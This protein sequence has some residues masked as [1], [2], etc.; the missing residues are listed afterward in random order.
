MARPCCRRAAPRPRSISERRRSSRSP[1]GAARWRRRSAVPST[2][3]SQ[4]AG[5]RTCRWS[6][7]RS[8]QLVPRHR[9]RHRR[10]A[11]S[12]PPTGAADASPRRVRVP[13]TELCRAPD[14]QRAHPR[15]REGGAPRRGRC[16]SVPVGAAGCD[17]AR[18][19]HAVGQCGDPATHHG[20]VPDARGLLHDRRPAGR[21]PS[22]G[23]VRRRAVGATSTPSN[24]EAIEVGAA[25]GGTALLGIL[26]VVAGRVFFPAETVTTQTLGPDGAVIDQSP[27]VR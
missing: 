20:D 27:A 3:R 1:A 11:G 21:H 23:R 25:L 22:P 26:L 12:T 8:N 15:G 18:A 16:Q 14:Q 9:P 19:R 24:T 4:F 5:I 2:A 17:P 6:T 10:G 13:R 7:A